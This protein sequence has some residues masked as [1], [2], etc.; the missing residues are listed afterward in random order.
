MST[1]ANAVPFRRS[2]GLGKVEL[3][4]LRRVAVMALRSFA[5]GGAREGANGSGAARSA[6]HIARVS[7]RPAVVYEGA[8]A[9]ASCG[10]AW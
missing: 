1:V 4:Q 3:S 7:L 5:V 8:G 2:H 10:S 9:D 6:R